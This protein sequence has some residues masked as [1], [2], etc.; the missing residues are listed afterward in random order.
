MTAE[1]LDR[2]LGAL[3]DR[4]RRAVIERLSS[5]PL[6]ASSLADAMDVSRPAMSKH[7]RILRDAGLVDPVF[8]EQDARARVY[9]LRPATLRTVRAWLDRVEVAWQ[10]QLEGFKAHPEGVARVRGTSR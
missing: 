4:T 2:T 1:E 6:R 8:D 10:G 5:G 7:L 9:H 3:A